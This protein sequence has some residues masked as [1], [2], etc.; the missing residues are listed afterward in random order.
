MC[1]RKIQQRHKNPRLSRGGGFWYQ[2]LGAHFA[3]A[4]VGRNFVDSRE[5]D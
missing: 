2:Y 3:I 1:I 4:L 5:S